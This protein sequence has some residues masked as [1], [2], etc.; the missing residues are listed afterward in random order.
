M[1]KRRGSNHRNGPHRVLIQRRSTRGHEHHLSAPLLGTSLACNSEVAAARQA[2]EAKGA[3]L[4]AHTML[5]TIQSLPR[6]S[7]DW[8]SFLVKK[9]S[10]LRHVSKSSGFWPVLS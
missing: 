3:E 10:G 6:S 5:L 4:P 7:S 1:A 9:T 8:K 2:S